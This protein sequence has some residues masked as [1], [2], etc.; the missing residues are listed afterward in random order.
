MTRWPECFSLLLLL[1]CLPTPLAVSY[2]IAIRWWRS[3]VYF[4][5]FFLLVFTRPIAQAHVGRTEKSSPARNI[6]ANPKTRF[7][8]H[9]SIISAG[10]VENKSPSSYVS[11]CINTWRLCSRNSFQLLS[12]LNQQSQQHPHLSFLSFFL[13]FYPP[14][15]VSLHYFFF[16]ISSSLMCAGLWISRVMI[17]HIIS[18]VRA[19]ASEIELT[20]RYRH[21]TDLSLGFLLRLTPP[22]TQNTNRELKKKKKIIWKEKW[23]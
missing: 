14:S 16:F 5:F 22:S 8:F 20:G 10:C 7:F 12:P 15:V 6:I 18:R 2:N 17:T 19:S 9:S 23:G 4:L 21:Y 3:I 11:C 13:I 1:L